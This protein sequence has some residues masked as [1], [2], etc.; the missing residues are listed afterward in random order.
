[1]CRM[2]PFA[3]VCCI[4]LSF[5]LRADRVAASEQLSAEQSFSVFCKQWVDT[6]NS[7]ARSHIACAQR[8]DGAFIAEYTACGDDLELRVKQAAA[9]RACFVGSLRYREKKYRSC[10]QTREGAMQGPFTLAAESNVTQL[11]LYRNGRWQY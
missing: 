11:F 10:A 1:M 3:V 2:R 5:C 7:Y 8:P 9:S 6:L 4:A